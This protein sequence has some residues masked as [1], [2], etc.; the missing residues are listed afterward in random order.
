M[1]LKKGEKSA[2]AAFPLLPAIRAGTPSAGSGINTAAAAPGFENPA[3]P[4]PGGGPDGAS[5]AFFGEGAVG[6]ARAAPR[7]H[8]PRR[9]RGP[10]AAPPRANGRRSRRHGITRNSRGVVDPG[11]PSAPPA[12]LFPRAERNEG[13]PAAPSLCVRAE[14]GGARAGPSRAEEGV[15]RRERR[16]GA[17]GRFGAGP[18][19][20]EE[21]GVGSAGRRVTMA[22]CARPPG[23]RER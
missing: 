22:R 2:D 18:R 3:R 17:G 10:R 16:R 21:G 4:F 14:R 1:D 12:P 9:L 13:A 19:G 5:A 11:L 15:E 23:G 8:S 6:Q 7:R 20:R